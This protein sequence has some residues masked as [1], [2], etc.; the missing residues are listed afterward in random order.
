MT[1]LR[2]RPLVIL[3][4][5]YTGKFLYPLAK[6]HGWHTYATSRSPTS[7][8]SHV[9]KNER[10][11]FDLAQSES[12]KQI[13]TDAHLIWCFPALPQETAADFL[14]T[15]SP[16]RGRLVML[17]STSAYEPK[18][19][20]FVDEHTSVDSSVPRVQS[21]EYFRQNYGAVVLRLAGLYGPGR[22][23]LDWMRK[24]KVQNTRKYVNLI[25][26]EDVAKICLAALEKAQDGENFVV[27]DG[28]PRQWSEI[29]SVATKRWD[30]CCPSLSQPK[31]P[32][33][34]LTIKKLTTTLQHT[35]LYPDL[36]EAL[37]Q[38]EKSQMPS[39][40]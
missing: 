18:H 27:S 14:N 40:K 10:L 31:N 35:F 20:A 36:Y 2:S 33:K 13:P 23:V 15:L 26:I 19:P 12:W 8:L 28:I 25:H 30:M 39:E 11:F 5:G 7:H 1:D 17:G 4:A 29:F 21:E 6:A 32:G 22:H 38:I 34:R 16:S 9:V 24:G 37:D 3:G